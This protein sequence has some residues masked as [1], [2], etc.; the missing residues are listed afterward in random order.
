MKEYFIYDEIKL[1]SAEVKVS[2]NTSRFVLLQLW[3]VI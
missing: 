2:E 1:L 3:K